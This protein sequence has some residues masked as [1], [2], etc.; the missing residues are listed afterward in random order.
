[1][2]VQKHVEEANMRRSM[3]VRM[4]LHVQQYRNYNTSRLFSM[5]I[6]CVTLSIFQYKFNRYIKCSRMCKRRPSGESSAAAPCRRGRSAANVSFASSAD[7]SGR[8]AP[9]SRCTEITDAFAY[10]DFCD[11][12]LSGFSNAN[13]IDNF[14]I[15]NVDA[16]LHNS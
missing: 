14:L 13:R 12:W 5:V 3:H 6:M 2:N 16:K 10:F 8:A 11:F 1:M 7:A 9:G 15:G 4:W